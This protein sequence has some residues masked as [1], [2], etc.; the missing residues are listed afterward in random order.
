MS[1]FAIAENIKFMNRRLYSIAL[2]G[3]TTA[4]ALYLASAMVVPST[5]YQFL[6]FRPIDIPTLRLSVAQTEWSRRPWLH[7]IVSPV[8]IFFSESKSPALAAL[9]I[10]PKSG[11][12]SPASLCLVSVGVLFSSTIS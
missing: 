8:V 5:L 9:S 2:F 7:I 4:T 1:R 11:T 12:V 6:S 3:G 10:F